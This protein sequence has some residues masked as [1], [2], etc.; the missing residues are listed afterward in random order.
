MNVMTDYEFR[1]TIIEKKRFDYLKKTYDAES[2]IF[3][4]ISSSCY[5]YVSFTICIC[6]VF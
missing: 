3:K 4:N 2:F 1:V 5:H 6:Y